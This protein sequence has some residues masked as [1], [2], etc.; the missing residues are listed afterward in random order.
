MVKNLKELSNKQ[1]PYCLYFSDEK[2]QAYAADINEVIENL[3]IPKGNN[4]MK[5]L[6]YYPYRTQFQ[7]SNGIFFNFDEV[8]KQMSE[9]DQKN[10][11]KVISITSIDCISW[12]CAP[13]VRNII[14]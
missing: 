6:N 11:C 7:G 12:E 10:D 3:N 13:D 1:K 2:G 5:R 14:T 4:Q 8:K 9:Q